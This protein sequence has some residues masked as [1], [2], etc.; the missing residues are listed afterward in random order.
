MRVL[1]SAYAC[2]PGKGSEPEAGLQIALAAASE[3]DVWVVTRENNLPSLRAFLKGHL[4]RERLHLVGLDVNGMP[5]RVKKRG[6][7][8]TLHWYY[9]AWQRRLAEV[10]VHLDD[11]IDFDVVH[12]ATFA[13]YWTRAGVAAVDK[14]FVWGPLGGGTTAPIALLPVMGFAG[15]FGDL[16]R[17]LFRPLIAS[18]TGAKKT[19]RRAAV[20][21]VQNPETAQRIRLQDAAVVLPHALVGVQTLRSPDLI[22]ASPV[23]PTRIV[24]AG[25]LVGWKA[26]ALAITAMRHIKH[27]DVTLEVYGSGPQRRRLERM[28][29]RLGVG[30]RIRFHGNVE[31]CDLLAALGSGSALVHPSLHEAAGFVVVEAL[32]MGTPVVALDRGGP[33]VLISYWPDVPSRVVQPST[34][35]VTARRIALALDEVIGQRGEPDHRPAD[36]FSEGLLAAYSQAASG[37]SP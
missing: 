8:P 9:D 31:R 22:Q 23:N 14:P 16:A 25:R 6:G 21:L 20:V 36:Q 27:T 18:L 29:T 26:T 30:H 32:A 35:G 12:H 7:L 2:E 11:E 15:A 37:A 24:S 5:K 13:A 34:P 10:A 19:A 1:V 17:V 4:L 33:P 28:T 3:H